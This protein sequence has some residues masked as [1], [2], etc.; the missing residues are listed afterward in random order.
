MQYC[1][2]H[3]AIQKY[4][5]LYE[6][7]MKA[8]ANKWLTS[9]VNSLDTLPPQ[10]FES[11]LSRFSEELFETTEYEFLLK[12][13]NS[14]IPFQLKKPVMKY[15]EPCCEKKQMPQLRWFWQLFNNDFQYGEKACGFLLDAYRSPDCDIKTLELVFRHNVEILNYGAHEMPIG[16]LISKEEY[17]QLSGQCE[18]IMTKTDISDSLIT[19]YKELLLQYEQ[20]R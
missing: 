12:R 4:A 19:R 14:Q 16:L 9:V 7:G 5:A 3:E 13:G 10:E 11:V 15:L 1:E 6:N 20:Y 17:E 18:D 2:F 8:D